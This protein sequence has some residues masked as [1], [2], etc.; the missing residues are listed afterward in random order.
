MRALL[1]GDAAVAEL[2]KGRA[3][4][5]VVDLPITYRK[6]GKGEGGELL[7]ILFFLLLLFLFLYLSL[8]LSSSSSLL[9][10]CILYTTHTVYILA[11]S[12]MPRLTS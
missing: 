5:L 1:L 6:V 12:R 10:G 9:V 8:F 7:C 11:S 2:R 4:A 3:D